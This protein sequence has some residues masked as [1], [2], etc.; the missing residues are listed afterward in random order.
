MQSD[1]FLKDKWREK[2]E[3]MCL[4]YTD[5]KKRRARGN[6]FSGLL[7]SFGYILSLAGAFVMAVKKLIT[8][9]QFS[10]CLSAFTDLQ[11]SMK[12][13]IEL[14]GEVPKSMGFLS[15]YYE[16]L[17]LEK[18]AGGKETIESFE[19]L[20]CEGVSFG[21]P[22]LD[23]L[24][25]KDLSLQI[26]KGEKVAIVGEN[27]SGKTTLIKLL[28]GQYPPSSGLVNWNGKDLSGISQTAVCG[29]SSVLPQTFNKYKMSL[30]DN[31]AI[32]DMEQAQNDE[33]IMEAVEKAGCQAVYEKCGGLD[34]MLGREFGGADLSGGEWQSLA[35]A[36]SL[37]K[38]AELIVLDEPTSALDAIKETEILSCYIESIR[39]KTAIIISH[40]IGMCR[41]MDKV[42]VMKNGRIAEIG[43]HEELLQKEG[44]YYRLYQAQ[45]KWYQ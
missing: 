32:S 9:G 22:G 17:D 7:V 37:F 4:L 45:R 25:L 10:A 1:G 5:Y 6:L 16:Y 33:K 41:L 18:E 42:I 14:I 43:T 11:S 34:E 29:L 12:E 28:L 3:H 44:E 19:G 38:P 8:V 15:D 24:V 39:E 26:Q 20:S 21:Y 40:R 2:N 13:C 23:T 35:M 36:R 31:I 30:R 27:G